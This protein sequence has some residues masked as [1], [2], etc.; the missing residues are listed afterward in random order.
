MAKTDFVM[1]DSTSHNLGI[2]E[3]VC[4]EVESEYVPSSLVCNIHPL[5]MMQRK[6]KQLFQV[7]H[8]KIGN[9]EIHKY[10]YVDVDFKSQS[11]PSKAIRCLT[12]FISRNFSTKP[13]NRQKYFDAFIY[14]KKNESFSLKDHRF[15]DIFECCYSYSRSRST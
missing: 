11:L 1:T 7:I 8:Y 3:M 5:M 2:I 6:V 4:E 10:F 9:N 14:P 15:N 13:W 12:S